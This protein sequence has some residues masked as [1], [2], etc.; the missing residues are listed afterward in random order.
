MSDSITQE[1]VDHDRVGRWTVEEHKNFLY[2]YQIHG[3]SWKNVAAYVKTRSVV[4]VRTHAQKYFQKLQKQG[5]FSNHLK[6]SDEM[7]SPNPMIKKILP[8][9]EPLPLLQSFNLLSQ[10]SCQDNDLSMFFQASSGEAGNSVTVETVK[11]D[12]PP[13]PIQESINNNPDWLTNPFVNSEYSE[14]FNDSSDSGSDHKSS[15][16]ST[17][18]EDD[19]FLEFTAPPVHFLRDLNINKF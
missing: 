15:F 6:F 12:T 8:P 11:Q 4:Q 19:I 2:G 14:V 16:D 1:F 13:A 10:K 17:E 7:R 18:D 5:E 9:P 3:K